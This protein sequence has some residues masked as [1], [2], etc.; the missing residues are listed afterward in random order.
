[1]ESVRSISTVVEQSLYLPKVEA[2][3]P[4]TVTAFRRGKMEG[5]GLGYIV[6]YCCARTI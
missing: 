1:M 6:C 3:N 2:L 5:K 4:E